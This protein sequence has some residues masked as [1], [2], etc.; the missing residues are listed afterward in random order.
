MLVTIHQPN[1]LPWFPF[2]EKAAKAD[3]FVLL[4]QCQFERNG[5]QNRAKIGNRVYTMPVNRRKDMAPIIEKDYVDY[6]TN[7]SNILS[8]LRQKFRTRDSRGLLDNLESQVRCHLSRGSLAQI[9]GIII[10]TMLNYL[11]IDEQKFVID[12]ETQAVGTERIIEVCQDNGASRYLAGPSSRK[13]LDFD[14]IRGAGIG[15]TLHSPQ[16]KIH[17]LEMLETYGLEEVRNIMEGYS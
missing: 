8:T 4:T 10:S 5:Y 6:E 14:A 1:F 13:Y 11:G 2:F 3:K 7:F 16:Y 9:N 15:V 17:T 12:R